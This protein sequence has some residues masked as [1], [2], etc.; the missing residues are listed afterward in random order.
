MRVRLIGLLTVSLLAGGLSSSGQPQVH[1]G[2]FVPTSEWGQ[3]MKELLNGSTRAKGVADMRALAERNKGTTTGAHALATAGLYCED[4]VLYRELL[5]QIISEYPNS[6]FSAQ[7]NIALANLTRH[8]NHQAWLAA[9]DQL[10]QSLGAPTLVEILRNRRAAVAKARSL[11]LE[12]LNAV[13]QTY[14][15]YA[16]I[17]RKVERQ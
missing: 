4:D 13:M 17:L 5:Q 14:Q 16:N 9:R 6:G 15:D 3:I 7:A 12:T 8:P 2:P 10:L 1:Y 11:P